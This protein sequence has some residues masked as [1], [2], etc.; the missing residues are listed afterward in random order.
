MSTRTEQD[1]ITL[2]AQLVVLEREIRNTT[3]MLTEKKFPAKDV[4]NVTGLM[5]FFR[6]TLC[7]DLELTSVKDNPDFACLC[8]YM[9]SARRDL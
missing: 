9:A 7:G 1:W 6:A 2:A 8:E 3:H 5:R 4:K